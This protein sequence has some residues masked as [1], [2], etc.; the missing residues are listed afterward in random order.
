M[1]VNGTHFHLIYG[2]TDWSQCQEDRLDGRAHVEW[3]SQ[4]EILS[5]KPR[6][7]LFPRGKR[8]TPLKPPDR[9][10]AA[11][12]RFG[13]WYWISND[14]YKIFW[15]PSGGDRPQVYWTQTPSPRP[16]PPGEFHSYGEEQDGAV[17]LAG[18][19]VTE[20]H[21][22]VVGNVTQAGLFIFDLHAGG[23]PLLLLFPAV[24]SSPPKRFAPFDIAPAPGGGVWVLDKTNRAYWGL[25][26]QFRI[27]TEQAVMHEIEPGQTFTFRPVGGYHGRP[28][29]PTVSRRLSSGSP[30]P[31]QHRSPTGW[32]R[33]H[34][35]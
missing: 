13:N 7:V 34:L 15:K 1:D 20:H 28:S 14:Q 22:L 27:V 35:G 19:A 29:R 21:Y 26:P 2:K 18:M 30:E 12:D 3:D 24:P 10:G 11:V 4:S 31:N 16:T 6:S 5:L 33:A 17:V 8:Y 32:Q 9:R 23:E 25:D